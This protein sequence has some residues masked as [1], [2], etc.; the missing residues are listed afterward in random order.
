MEALSQ[1]ST[2]LSLEKSISEGGAARITKRCGDGTRA[3]SELSTWPGSFTSM[4]SG[5]L[6]AN[7][8][9][10]G[11][12][13]AT[14]VALTFHSAEYRLFDSADQP[15]GS[16]CIERM[17]RMRSRRKVISSSRRLTQCSSTDASSRST[18]VSG[19]L[20]SEVVPVM[21]LLSRMGLVR[22]VP[23]NSTSLVSACMRIAGNTLIG[24]VDDWRTAAGKVSRKT[25]GVT[26]AYSG[27]GGNVMLRTVLFSANPTCE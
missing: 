1:P 24:S 5:S 20:S 8:A 13:I 9:T 23:V 18:S 6:M 4:V 12:R 14:S 11:N 15:R 2:M 3:R 26:M 22:R 21:R 10:G 27:M 7:V 19:L 16:I 17:P 25:S